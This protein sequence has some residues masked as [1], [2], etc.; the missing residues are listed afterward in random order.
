[1]L[2][3]KIN[4]KKYSIPYKQS[5]IS[6]S[7]GSQ[8]DSLVE[9]YTGNTSNEEFQK[10]VVSLLGNINY[11]IVNLVDQKQLEIVVKNH[12]YFQPIQIKYFSR[13]IK[14]NR[15]IYSYIDLDDINVR[16]FGEMDIATTE[17][18]LLK[19][20][21]LLYIKKK[22]YYWF[23]YPFVKNH[24]DWDEINYYRFCLTISTYLGWKKELLD[25]YKLNAIHPDIEPDQ[26]PDEYKQQG[27][28]LWGVYHIVMNICGNDYSEFEKWL[29]RSIHELL[30]FVKYNQLQALENQQNNPS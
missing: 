8:L 5:E 24:K 1:M 13:I 23:K 12:G 4:N 9:E 19:L 16:V 7:V 30:K 22:W 17:K 27:L 21:Q 18:N 6:Y 10:W 2:K 25:N 20:F 29:S 14:V 28:E 15:R 26:Q 11:D 3:V